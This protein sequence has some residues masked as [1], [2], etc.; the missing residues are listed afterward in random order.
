MDAGSLAEHWPLIAGV[1][2]A[3]FAAGFAGGL[4]G[5]GGGIVTVPALYAVF[6]SF[7]VSENESLKTAIGTSLAV[8]IVTSLRSLMT[9]HRAGHADLRI[10]RAW[11]PWIALGAAAGG[12]VARW[13]PAEALTVV[14]AG[15]ALYVGWR[16][17]FGRSAAKDRSGEDLTNKRIH[18]PI[19]FGTGL[20]SSLMGIGGGALGVMVMTWSG[21]SMHQ[22]VGTASGFGVAVALPGAAGFILSGL[23]HDGLPPF[24]LGF[25]NLAAFAAMAAMSAIAAPLGARLAHRTEAGFLSKLFGAYVL[26]AAL[27]LTWDMFKQG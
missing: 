20:F 4:F 23:G 3:G 13:I 21:R 5:I 19:G 9:H 15:G 22:A 18:I 12:M 8:I 6:T 11:A 2:A 25:V 16:R 17:L 27:A 24:S 26:A 1:I 10:L 14:F 7:N